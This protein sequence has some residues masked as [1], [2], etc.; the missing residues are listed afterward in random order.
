MASKT[1]TVE[2]YV[3]VDSEGDYGAGV[4]PEGAAQCYA[5][6]VGDVAEKDGFRMVKILLTVPLP[7][8]VV[9]TGTVPEQGTAVLASVE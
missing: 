4:D 3:M 9:L 1:E 6:N 7:V 2:V 5:D 8:E